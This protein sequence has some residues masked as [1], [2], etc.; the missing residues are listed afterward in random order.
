MQRIS[1]VAFILVRHK[2]SEK[3]KVDED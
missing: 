3:G 2:Q 1:E